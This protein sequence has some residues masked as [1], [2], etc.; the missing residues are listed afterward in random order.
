MPFS[1]DDLLRPLK[2][3]MN[4][5]YIQKKSAFVLPGFPPRAIQP[6]GRKTGKNKKF[7][8]KLKIFLAYILY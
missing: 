4:N 1:P 7:L 3:P 2:K 8:Q 5:K 6:Q